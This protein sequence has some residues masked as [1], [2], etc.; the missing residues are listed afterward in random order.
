[1]KCPVCHSVV[2][3]DETACHVCGCR[4]GLLCDA[5][6][7]IN[8]S[9]SK[10]CNACGRPLTGSPDPFSRPNRPVDHEYPTVSKVSPQSPRGPTGGSE[11]KQVTVL[12]SDLSGYTALCERLDP[13][14]VREMM[15]LIFKEIVG[16]II[17][18][19]GYIDR[20]IGDEVLAVFGIPRIHEDDPIRAIRAALDIHSTVSGMSE[21]FER[22]LEGPLAMH[23]GIATGLVVTGEIDLATGRHGITGETVNRAS[24]LTTLA[25]SDEILVGPGTMALTSGFFLFEKRSPGADDGNADIIDAY[26]VRSAEKKPD[27]IR[28]L[29]GLRSRLIGREAE[30]TALREAMAEASR[31]RGC[32]VFIEGDAGTGKSRLIYEFKKKLVPKHVQWLQGNAYT[33]TQAM[34]YSPLIELLG[35][36]VDLREGDSET[37]VRQKLVEI[38]RPLEGEDGPIAH[39]LERL[40]I[41]SRD[42]TINITPEAWKLKLRQALIQLAISYSQDGVT[43][44]CIEDLHWADP[45]TVDLLRMM[46]NNA[47]LPVFFLISYRPGLLTFNHRQITNPYYRNQYI[48]IEDLPPEKSEAMVRSLLQTEEV[49]RRLLAFIADHLGGNPFFLEE[50]I[51]SLVDDGILKKNG[52]RWQVRGIIGDTAFSSNISSVIAARLDSLGD[53]DKRIVQEASAIG[54]RFSPAVLK[55]ISANPKRIDG[56]VALLKLLGLIFDGND[57][58][59]DVYV[60][61]HALVQEVAYKSLLKRQRKNLHER[62]GRVLERQGAERI[63]ALC[64][65]LA[66]HFSNGHSLAKAVNYLKLSGRKGLKKY[67]VIESHNYYEKAYQLLTDKARPVD[68]AASRILE[69]LLEWFFVFHLRGHYGDVLTLLERH[70]SSAMNSPDLQL[71]GMY[72]ACLGWAHQRREHLDSSRRC[73][74]E[75]IA[76]GE[77]ITSYK[78]IA[79]ANACLIWT[80]TDLGRLDEALVFAGKAEAASRFF[81]SEDSSWFFETGQN[82]VRFVLTGTAIAHWFR[83]DCR[84]CHKLGDRLLAYGESAGDVNSLSEGHLAHGMGC[85]AAGD[86]RAA[87]EKCITAIDNSGDPLFDVNARFLMA[88]AHLSL[89]EVPQAEKKLQEIITFCRQ[90]G[91]E[92]IGTSANALASVIAVARGEIATGVK[93]LK[94]HAGQHLANGK[95]YHAQ[96]F[97]Y[98]L[99]SI[100]LQIAMREGRLTPGMVLK[101]LSFFLV[102]L[103]RAA[104]HA[105]HHFK[106]AIRIASQINAMGIKGQACLDL[107]RLY[108]SRKNHDLALPLIKESIAL[109]KQLGA[110]SHQQRATAV[111]NT[112]E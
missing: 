28:R 111:L 102:N 76:I 51:N 16:I 95:I 7:T 83:G 77:Q 85:F 54:R 100:F 94:R 14:D 42:N 44:I 107:G 21:R 66:F 86:Y 72:F 109:F 19:E 74:L 2:D 33:F 60:F 20:I 39:V 101:N 104:R 15:S 29:R 10:F 47:A 108:L 105:E 91:Y 61:K 3:K 70:E 26:R 58:G 11:R 73:L 34:P 22:Q 63:D 56:S 90:S 25:A 75:A 49:P 92:Y 93:T 88:Y 23:S 53:A 87:I 98:M 57:P 62:I 97:H 103:P 106:T 13:E 31:G 1:M 38:L 71:K 8:R 79:Y 68:D 55:R 48:L 24:V 110:D 112:V 30:M 12:F 89:G 27:K 96:T 45:S 41:H 6:G 80:C 9:A 43:I 17:R 4:L 82:L 59:E 37:V 32:C 99:G 46:L 35:R 50:L 40:F 69:L 5:C 18:Y 67:A 52:N 84:Q 65:P 81:E 36:A 78:V 64:E